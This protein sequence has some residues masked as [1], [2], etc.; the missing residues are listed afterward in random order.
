MQNND[1]AD[2]CKQAVDIPGDHTATGNQIY[3]KRRLEHDQQRNQHSPA[4]QLAEPFLFQHHSLPIIHT[5]SFG[6]GLPKQPHKY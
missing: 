5:L 3:Q 6:K 1:D 2:K 4:K